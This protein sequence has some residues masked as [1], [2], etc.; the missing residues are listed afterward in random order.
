MDAHLYMVGVD[1]VRRDCALEAVSFLDELVLA[2]V[3]AFEFFRDG[4]ELDV[5]FEDCAHVGESLY[6]HERELGLQVGLFPGGRRESVVALSSPRE[7][8]E[9]LV[10]F[11]VFVDDFPVLLYVFALDCMGTE[12]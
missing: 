9:V 11:R 3:C 2:S 6:A 4:F 5:E 10:E 7:G 1:A 12:G 8:R